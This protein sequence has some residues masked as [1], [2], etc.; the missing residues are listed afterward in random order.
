[1]V[2]TNFNFKGSFTFEESDDKKNVDIIFSKKTSRF[3]QHND[4]LNIIK[5]PETNKVVF[6][7]VRK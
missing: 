4:K 2:T 3:L 5:D 1:M 6:E 7:I